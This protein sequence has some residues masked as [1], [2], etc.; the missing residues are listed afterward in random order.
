MSLQIIYIYSVK[1]LK[2]KKKLLKKL[3]EQ[4]QPQNVFTKFYWK[5]IFFAFVALNF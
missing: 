3:R 4:R 5:R 1:C 2:K